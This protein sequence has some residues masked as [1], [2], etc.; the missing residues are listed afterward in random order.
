MTVAQGATLIDDVI[1]PRHQVAPVM[2]TRAYDFDFSA[3]GVL[4]LKGASALLGVAVPYQL[5][6]A[7]L[8]AVL[9]MELGQGDYRQDFAGIAPEGNVSY[10]G[11]GLLVGLKSD[12]WTMQGALR[13]GYLQSD[14]DAYF[15]RT[16]D[17]VAYDYDTAY[18]ALSL[19]GSYQVPI[20][21]TVS[22]VPQLRYDLIYLS[23]DDFTI[24]HKDRNDLSMDA[25]TLNSLRVGLATHWQATEQLG[26]SLGVYGRHIFS[27]RFT[28]TVLG[29][30]IPSY[31]L[32]GTSYGVNLGAHGTIGPLEYAA[33]LRASWAD[34][35]ERSGQL[36]L[37]W[38]F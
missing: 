37:T 21:H 28:G 17:Q 19:K 25:M 32:D 29:Y 3:Q 9:F 2:A 27:S 24:E 15:E 10:G 33:V 12:H 11:L 31:Q 30:E 14:F 22:L 4:E 16:K 26:L 38:P 1:L 7:D 8:T 36:Q 35:N 18:W 34:L 23:P 5:T 20:T 13:G 6:D